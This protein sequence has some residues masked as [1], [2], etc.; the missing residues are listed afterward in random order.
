MKGWV[1]LFS[2]VL[3][4]GFIAV[5]ALQQPAAPRTNPIDV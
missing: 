4:G 2:L 1:V 3:V 5:G